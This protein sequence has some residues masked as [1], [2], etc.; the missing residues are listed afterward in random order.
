MRTTKRPA[1]AIQ[2]KFK[3]KYNNNSNNKNTIM[4]ITKTKTYKKN[5]YELYMMSHT[6]EVN[7]RTLNNGNR[8]A[9]EWLSIEFVWRKR[10]TEKEKN[11]E[12]RAYGA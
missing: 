9:A 12:K 3:P 6:Q 1:K 5:K 4:C 7:R 10:V 2:G 8:M 11:K